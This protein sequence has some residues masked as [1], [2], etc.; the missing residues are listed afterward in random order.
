ML[1]AAG[2]AVREHALGSTPSVDFSAIL[3]AMI[4]VGNSLDAAV[5]Q[6]RR[7]RAELG[8]DIVPIVW[9]LPAAS[10]EAA[11]RGLEAGA[12]VVLARPL[13]PIVFTAQASSAARLRAAGSRLAARA[14]ESRLLGDQ[15]QKAL[16]HMDRD[17][18]TVRRVQRAFLPRSLPKVGRFSFA[19][20]HR[21]RSR[22]GG[23][24]YDV[25]VIDSGRIGFS[26]SDV[27]GSSAAAGLL[28]AF[29]AQSLAK[30]SDVP[31]GEALEI[32]NREVL[33]LTPD[34]RPLVAMLAGSLDA[35]TGVVDL[36]RAGLPAPIYLP[37][38]GE[39]EI[40]SIPGPFLGT[41]EASYATRSRLLQPGDK[42]VLGTDG[43]R[44]DGNPGPG[45]D[46]SLLETVVCHRE[47]SGQAFADTVANDLLARVR[48]E[49]DFTLL[50]IEMH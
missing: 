44:L 1:D 13:D 24:F 12:D 33:A 11:A 15:L 5:S 31:P 35:N 8:D 30:R 6:T 19:V 37:S 28:G 25:R 26:L 7:W 10:A 20:S 45:D 22:T 32:V 4:D 47:L 50:V 41:A 34:D 43:T 9:V 39:P 46:D 29:A 42:L 3:F 36:A 2:Q 16:A 14:G 38:V 40:G 48:H 18:D 17:L 27:I 49:D 21:A 23:D